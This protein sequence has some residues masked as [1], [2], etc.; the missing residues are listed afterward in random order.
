[1]ISCWF[2]RPYFPK[3]ASSIRVL[4]S[5]W[6]SILDQPDKS[7]ICYNGVVSMFFIVNMKNDPFETRVKATL[8]LQR[9]SKVTTFLCKCSTLRCNLSGDFQ[10]NQPLP[11]TLRVY[12]SKYSTLRCNLLCDFLENQFLPSTLR[13]YFPKYSTLPCNL[14][15]KFLLCDVFITLFNT[16]C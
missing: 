9:L 4:T 3:H 13:I 8:A 11:S 14:L 16:S 1:M 10:E 7:Y 6:L 5:I 2:W 15:L 12:F